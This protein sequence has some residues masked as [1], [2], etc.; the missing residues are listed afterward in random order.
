MYPVYSYDKVEST[1]SI[2]MKRG[3]AGAKHGTSIIAVDQTMGRGRLGKT[4]FSRRGKGLYCSIIVRPEIKVVDFPKLT[5]VAGLAVRDVVAECVVSEPM[6]KWPND[7]FIEGKKCGGILAESGNVTGKDR[8]CVIGIG[9]NISHD[10][11]DFP[12]ELQG[13]VTSLELMGSTPI[14]AD[15]LLVSLRTA[16]LGRIA[17]MVEVGFAPLLEIWR[18]Y[19]FL[20]GKH[21]RCIDPGGNL[22][23]GVSLGPD[24][25]GVLCLRDS[26][27]NVHQVLSGDISLAG[28]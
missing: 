6:L 16:L 15:T 17:Q 26:H 23:E 18:G 3:V 2:A 12:L 28:V 7:I 20:L 4:W 22:I 5:L 11:A 10:T 24:D 1:N 21:M 14:A 13:N 25:Q 27:G 19:D 8:F 9:L